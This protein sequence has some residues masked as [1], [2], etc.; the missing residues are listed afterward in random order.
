MIDTHAHLNFPELITTIEVIINEA[1]QSGI[2][3]IIV[4]SVDLESS[5][6]TV[7]ICKKYPQLRPAIG[8][9][10][11]E[12]G[13]VD[14]AVLNSFQKLITDNRSILVAIGEVGLDY[15]YN[16][17]D[18]SVQKKVFTSMLEYA[19]SSALPFIMHARDAGQEAL[20]LVKNVA[21]LEL[22]KVWHCFDSSY[23]EATK[24]LDLGGY[25]SFTG[26][27]TYRKNSFL[28]EIA[29]KLPLERIMLETDAPYLPPEGY[30]GERCTPSMLNITAQCLAEIR[31]LS[32][33][34]I[35]V[36]TTK[37]AN[38]FFKLS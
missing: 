30:R 16:D 32:L 8:F 38:L 37:N 21:D 17:T 34:A 33:E 10:P 27:L 36:V 28:R 14:Q 31:G 24:W 15:H 2:S 22:A 35:D 5:V 20:E 11:S 23:E 13:K 4:P 7:D 19:N 3:I 29:A 12:S 6:T 1:V 18:R 9:H 26:M 25:I